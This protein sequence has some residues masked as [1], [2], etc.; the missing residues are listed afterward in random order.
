MPTAA[1]QTLGTSGDGLVKAITPTDNK[2]SVFTIPAGISAVTA[3][4]T[5]YGASLLFSQSVA[6]ADSLP[7][8]NAGGRLDLPVNSTLDISPMRCGVGGQTAW[9]VGVAS[10]NGT[11]FPTVQMSVKVA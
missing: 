8:V 11:D 6:Q 3:V 5:G 7:A 9:T 4:I 1:G 2:V 10:T